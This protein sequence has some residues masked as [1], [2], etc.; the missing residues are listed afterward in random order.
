MSLISDIDEAKKLWR[1]AS[2]LMRGVI[3]LVVFLSV[4]SVT[5]LSNVIF[6]WKGF[7]LDAINV[8]RAW[9][10]KPL[11]VLG[12]LV[13]LKYFSD[14][15]LDALVIISIFYATFYR[16]LNPSTKTFIFLLLPFMFA[17]IAA[18]LYPESSPLSDFILIGV[19]L[20]LLVAMGVS[21]YRHDRPRFIR[22]FGPLVIAILM[23]LLLGGINSGISR[24]S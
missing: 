16:S 13:G 6:E 14:S 19:I 24:P 18:G 12:S 17:F 2:W 9:V 20:G 22:G 8:Y 5:S 15:E 3:A 21:L 4:S 7:I 1:E 11:G 10:A 23:V